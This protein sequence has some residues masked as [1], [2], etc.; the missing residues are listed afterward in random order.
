[1]IETRG[2]GKKYESRWAVQGLNLNLN[3]GE[4]YGFL[5]PNGADKTTTIL[6]LLNIV[7][8]TTGEILLFGRKLNRN[9]EE[10]RSRI[11]VVPE[12]Q[13]FY[14]EMT[15]REYLRFFGEI[16]RVPKLRIKIEE[17][18]EQ[19]DVSAYLDW[20]LRTFSRGM[21]QKAAF[22]RAFLHNPELLI[23]DEP[24]S[25]LDPSGVR[26]IRSLIKNGHEKGK[27]FLISSHMLSEVEKL[28]NKAAI[29][30]QGRLIAEDTVDNLIKQV[31]KETELSL[32]FLEEVHYAAEIL[33]E[34]KFVNRV[35]TDG[36]FLTA[37]VCS[38]KDYRRDIVE[39]LVEK[40]IVPVGIY[41]RS[42]SL[43]DAFFDLTK[44]R[45]SSFGGADHEG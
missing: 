44:E 18:A 12:R 15:L 4:I 21:Q 39:V 28:C 23:L 36:R 42:L 11:G 40:G 24:I 8:P 16:Y 30:D 43:E 29:I 5:G 34:I 35:D 7:S 27:T 22:S 45:T 1:M 20:Q 14:P 13:N 31:T 9:F 10:I 37:A 2:L 3:K 25:G 26:Q 33:R 6:M 19:N 17:I 38:D 32:E 41:V